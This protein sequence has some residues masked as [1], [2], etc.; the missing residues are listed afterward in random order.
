[1]IIDIDSLKLKSKIMVIGQLIAVRLYVTVGLIKQE[2]N[3]M[4]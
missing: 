4:M 3:K 2:E 1:M